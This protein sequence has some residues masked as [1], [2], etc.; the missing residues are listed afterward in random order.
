MN[1]VLLPGVV[2]GPRAIVG[3]GSI[4]TRSFPDG[5]CVITGNPARLQRTL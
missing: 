1:S 5:Q 2:L 4:V 3:A